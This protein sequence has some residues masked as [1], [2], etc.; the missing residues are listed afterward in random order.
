MTMKIESRVAEIA[1]EVQAKE[2][3]VASDNRQ[4]SV[5]SGSVGNSTSK[6]ISSKVRTPKDTGRSK[7]PVLNPIDVHKA[8]EKLNKIAEAQKKDVSFSVDEASESTVI[9][10]F[11]KNTGELIKQFPS[12]EILAMRAR[13]KKTTGWLYDS[14]A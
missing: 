1:Q 11:R 13:I 6:P 10:I 9:K 14:K 2:R 4:R 7:P 8:V 5:T 12:E 3:P